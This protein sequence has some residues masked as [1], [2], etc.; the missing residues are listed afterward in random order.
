MLLESVKL[1]NWEFIL[2]LVL[3]VAKLLLD[4]IVVEI[5]IVLCVKVMLVKNGLKMNQ[6]IY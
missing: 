6:N 3:N 5:D 4:I 2:L 1:K